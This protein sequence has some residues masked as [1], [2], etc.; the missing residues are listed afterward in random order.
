MPIFATETGFFAIFESYIFYSKPKNTL[1]HINIDVYN[2]Q[3]YCTIF[4]KQRTKLEIFTHGSSI[5]QKKKQDLLD[6]NFARS[7]WILKLLFPR[8]PYCNKM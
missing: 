6:H 1:S 4:G 2:F 8:S 5:V 3:T 7:S